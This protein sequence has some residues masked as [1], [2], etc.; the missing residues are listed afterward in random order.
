MTALNVKGG[1]DSK[2]SLNCV[3]FATRKRKR[4]TL[5]REFQLA[6]GLNSATVTARSDAYIQ[7]LAKRRST[8]DV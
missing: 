6:S 3:R 5:D 2:R 4:R 7:S 8:F 1:V